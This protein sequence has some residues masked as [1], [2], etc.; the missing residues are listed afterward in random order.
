MLLICGIWFDIYESGY[1]VGMVIVLDLVNLYNGILIIWDV[2]KLGGV[3][4]ILEFNYYDK[5]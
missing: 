1:G 3:E 5:K 4:F 2:E